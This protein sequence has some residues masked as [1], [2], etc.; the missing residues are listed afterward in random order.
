MSNELP[1]HAT[2]VLQQFSTSRAGI[3]IF[4]DQIIESVQ[5]GEVSALQVRVWIKSMEEI[6]ERVK[7][8]TNQNQITAAEKYS[9][10]KFEFAGAT[11]EKADF[12]KYD[13]SVCQ[14]MEWEL[15]DSQ[16]KSFAD[17]RRN[18]ELFLRAIQKPTAIITDDGEARTI[19][20]PMK[21]SNPGLKVSIK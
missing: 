21:R 20:P 3:D 5:Q 9:E 14:D 1:T 6:I 18:R 8:E 10:N 4:S 16:E 7:K 19:Y 2:G 13:F 12:G 15:Y 11:I 17:K